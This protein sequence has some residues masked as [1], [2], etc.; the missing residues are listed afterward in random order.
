MGKNLEVKEITNKEYDKLRHYAEKGELY[1]PLIEQFKIRLSVDEG[2]LDEEVKNLLTDAKNEI[3]KIR[4]DMN[5]LI[6]ENLEIK[7]NCIIMA[8]QLYINEQL[9]KVKS[10]KARKQ[11]KKL[12]LS[13]DGD[14]SFIDRKHI[15][16]FFNVV[17]GEIENDG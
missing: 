1:L 13:C 7:E 5:T 17:I 16:N 6:G 8:K 10:K 9:L 12:L 11:I 3:I 15:D 2:L 4:S 14:V